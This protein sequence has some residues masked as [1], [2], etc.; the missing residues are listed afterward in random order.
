VTRAAFL[1]LLAMQMHAAAPIPPGLA[2]QYFDEARAACQMDNGR[3]WGTSLCGPMLFVHPQSRATAANQADAEG[4]LTQSDG[5]WAGTFPTELNVANT[6]VDWAGVHWTMVM[7]PLPERDQPRLRLMLHESFHRIQD[8]VGLAGANPSNRH[9]DTR[10]G[11]IWLQMEWRA[12]ETALVSSGPARAEAVR[13]ALLFRVH[14][15][16]LFP[17]ADKEENALER[18]EG[19]AEYT[20]VK[21]SARSSADMAAISVAI[22]RSGADR[23]TF[24][25]SFAYTSGP[26]CGA[27]LDASGL[28]WR[29][30]LAKSD[31]AA[32]LASAYRVTASGDA[33]Q[34]AQAYGGAELIAFETARDEERQKR[35][36][37]LRARFQAGRVLTLPLSSAMRYAFNPNDILAL[38]DLATYYGY[39]RISDEWGILEVSDGAMLVREGGA[40]KYVL[41]PAPADPS[42]RKT[43]GWTLT[44]KPGWEIG[45]DARLRRDSA[46]PPR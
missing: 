7:W 16:K 41:V 21:L 22:L 3:L 20:G 18:N 31:F 29:P 43:D 12:F 44:L 2:K 32:L 17:G 13:D 14:R 28:D 38:D 37:G 39:L 35:I 23:P 27:L 1:I 33:P 15:Q 24:S 46:A 11:R 4:K 8:R 19:A 36:A 25:R 5:V 6:S 30:L 45:P 9:M 42:A 26:A 34:R 40:V 10:D